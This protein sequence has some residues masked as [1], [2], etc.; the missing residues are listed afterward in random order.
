MPRERGMGMT[1]ISSVNKEVNM[2][3][4]VKDLNRLENCDT[5]VE[6]LCELDNK[7]FWATIRACIKIRK[8]NK[9]LTRNAERI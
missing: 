3:I 2:E 8:A 4:K 6:K 9:I 7:S 1:E 5:I